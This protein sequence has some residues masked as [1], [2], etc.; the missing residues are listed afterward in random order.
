MFNDKVNQILY[1]LK[2]YYLMNEFSIDCM[3][4]G[5]VCR[6]CVGSP[7]ARYCNGI[8]TLLQW[9]FD[10]Y[11]ALK[12]R[13]CIEKQAEIKRTRIGLIANLQRTYSGG[14][15]REDV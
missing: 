15:G 10:A 13:L 2:K 1:I 8:S 11:G 9:Y 14:W 12:Y 4:K 5:F 3:F 6:L 7:C